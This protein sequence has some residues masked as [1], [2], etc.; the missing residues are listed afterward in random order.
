MSWRYI[1]Q[2][3]TT[4]EF[5]DLDLPIEREDL[6]WTLSGAGSLRG[7]VA[8]DVGALRAEDGSLL[9]EEWGTLIYAEADDEIRWGGILVSSQ[10]NGETWS[11]EAAGFAT[12]PHGLP[13][14]GEFV[15]IGMDP[16]DAVREIWR[17]IQGYPNGNLGVVV[18]DVRTPVRLGTPA[19]TEPDGDGGTRDVEAKPYAL[20]WW[21]TS[22]CGREIETLS[23]DTP[24]DFTERHH[25][26]GETVA[27]SIE[28]GYPRLGRRREDLVFVQGDNVSE[29]VV[30]EQDG[31]DFANAVIGIGAGEGPLSVHRS[32]AVQDGR[33]RRTAVYTDKT[34]SDDAR[35]DQRIADELTV[36]RQNT[37]IRS[38]TVTSHPNAV[39]GSWDLGDDV[40]IQAEVPWLGEVALW[41]R[42]TAWSLKD[43]NTAVLTLARSDSFRYGA[44]A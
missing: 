8:P 10:F 41:C 28:I 15:Q 40:L 6:T 21:E 27:H 23:S 44:A 43:E 19:T 31:D 7:T 11:I 35:M 20:V 13:Y 34:L 12:Y 37:E 42:I 24:F 16:T 5:L 36:R 1:A 38:V 22:D 30:V 39:I 29:V 3:A 33:L 2:R 4:G 9:L 18:N 26:T 14:E 17:H 25:W 32:T